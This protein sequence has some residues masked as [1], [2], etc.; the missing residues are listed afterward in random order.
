[1]VVTSLSLTGASTILFGCLV[2]CPPGQVFFILSCILRFLEGAGFAGY[3]TGVLS[4]LVQSFPENPGYY[5][6]IL[7]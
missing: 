5:V 7:C 3:F 4:V 1:M 6:V 2:W